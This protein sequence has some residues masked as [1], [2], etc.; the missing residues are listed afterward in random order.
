[1]KIM[2]SSLFIEKIKGNKTMKQRSK[3]ITN[4]QSRSNTKLRKTVEKRKRKTARRKRKRPHRTTLSGK[5]FYTLESFI[6]WLHL[7]LKDLIDKKLKPKG[8]QAVYSNK[9][10]W[11][12]LLLRCIMGLAHLTDIVERL[13]NN[14][15]LCHSIG[16]KRPFQNTKPLTEFMLKLSFPLI[17]WLF[18]H[19]LLE[20]RSH[21]L[22]FGKSVCIDCCYLHVFG[23]TYENTGQGYSGQLKRTANGYKLWIVL[24]VESKVPVAFHLDSGNHSDTTYF[25]TCVARARYVLGADNLQYVFADRGFCS[26]ELYYWLDKVM[27]LKFVIRAKGGKTNAYIQKPVDALTETD[28]RKLGHQEKYAKTTVYGFKGSEYRLFIGRNR[29]YKNPLMLLT[30]DFSLEWRAIKRKYLSRWS[31]ETFIAREKG[32]FGLGKFTGTKWELV[33][34]DV[35]CSLLACVLLQAWRLLLGKRYR[36]YGWKDL[37]ERVLLHGFTETFEEIMRPSARKKNTLIPAI[38]RVFQHLEK[39]DVMTKQE[40]FDGFRPKGFIRSIFSLPD[41]SEIPNGSNICAQSGCHKRR[42]IPHVLEKPQ[43]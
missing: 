39:W 34:A 40:R 43:T 37:I 18:L 3:S 28:Y 5:R 25:K 7:F 38:Q 10:C 42:E 27:K 14:L 2:V 29:K 13:R 31:V 23:K 16:I 41:I 15:S 22:V 30:N 24:S 4:H 35:F 9:A 19:T 8:A 17:K 1:M 32:C 6:R 20:M 21:G 33:Q 36:K 11:F 12:T 26:R